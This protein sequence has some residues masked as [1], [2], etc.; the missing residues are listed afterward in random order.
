MQPGKPHP[1]FIAI[2]HTFLNSMD[3]HVSLFA[4]KV[5]DYHKN[6]TIANRY[7][8]ST[9]RE[10]ED[11]DHI[12]VLANIA[13]TLQSLT[14]ITDF[15]REYMDAPESWSSI[16][17]TIMRPTSFDFLYQIIF[18]PGDIWEEGVLQELDGIASRGTL[19]VTFKFVNGML[20]ILRDAE[21]TLFKAPRLAVGLGNVLDATQHLR[22]MLSQWMVLHHH[23]VMNRPLLHDELPEPLGVQHGFLYPRLLR[24]LN[25][26]ACAVKEYPHFTGVLLVDVDLWHHHQSLYTSFW[27][28]CFAL[29][30]VASSHF[31]IIALSI[32]LFSENHSDRVRKYGPSSHRR[33]VFS[34]PPFIVAGWLTAHVWRSCIGQLVGISVF[35]IVMYASGFVVIESDIGQSSQRCWRMKVKPNV[36][37]KELARVFI[38]DV[39]PPWHAHATIAT[40]ISGVHPLGYAMDVAAALFTIYSA[41]RYLSDPDGLQYS[42][43]V[44]QAIR[45]RNSVIEQTLPIMPSDHARLT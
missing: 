27:M 15:I 44:L 13:S 3:R 22:S 31:W 18:T 29:G 16:S 10:A 21:L 28:A 32:F 37:L 24:T 7:P 35:A 20:A 30:A 12:D 26:E 39:T 45:V 1:D 11:P 43:G 17:L 4:Q 38:R 2:M 6:K 19:W 34:L 42:L 23:N 40:M 33:M 5:V 25:L 8:R 36:S 9:S 14:D 41:V